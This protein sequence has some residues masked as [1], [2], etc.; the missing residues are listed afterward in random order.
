MRSRST[1][2]ATLGVLLV[3]AGTWVLIQSSSAVN[4]CRV[5]NQFAGLEQDPGAQQQCASTNT[6][7]TA[8]PW[9]IGLGILFL[10]SSVVAAASQKQK[11]RSDK[12]WRRL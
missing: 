2:A 12:G 11:I 7:V 8:A 5:L 4:G 3:I 9:A 10:I 1:Y 6:L